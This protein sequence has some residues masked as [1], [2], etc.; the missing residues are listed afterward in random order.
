[1]KPVV[2]TGASRGIGKATA[3]KF[4]DEGW[5]VIG[6]STSGGSTL[7]HANL[8]L[9]QLDLAALLSSR[10]IK[11]SSFDPGWVKTD[12]GGMGASRDPSEPARE[13]FEPATSNVDSGYFWHRGRKRTW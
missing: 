10:R 2:I 8:H 3:Q 4:L 1:M 7:V 11:A 9:F 13:L 5:A 6:T 12:M